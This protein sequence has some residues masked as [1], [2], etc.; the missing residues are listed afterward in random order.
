MKYESL[1]TKPVFIFLIFTV[2]FGLMLVLLFTASNR[3][4]Q[5]EEYEFD[6]W[7][8][9][10]SVDFVGSH[11]VTLDLQ[12]GS[13]GII[14][15]QISA[16]NYKNQ[17]Q[18]TSEGGFSFH[19]FADSTGL[20][21]NSVGEGG[22][23]TT[24][25]LT[26]YLKNMTHITSDLEHELQYVTTP[27]KI[28]SQM[29]LE[30]GQII[31]HTITEDKSSL[32]SLIGKINSAESI[33]YL[34]E[35]N[36]RTNDER[37][38]KFRTE[39]YTTKTEGGVFILNTKFP[40]PP[41]AGSARERIARELGVTLREAKQLL[42]QYGELRINNAIDKATKFSSR[43]TNGDPQ[44]AGG[45]GA[46][47]NGIIPTRTLNDQLPISKLQVYL[48]GPE[49]DGVL[50]DSTLYLR[51][52]H[53]KTPQ[54]ISDMPSTIAVHEVNG[55]S[56]SGGI[57]LMDNFTF[58][59]DCDCYQYEFNQDK[60]LIDVDILKPGPYV[61]SVDFSNARHLKLPITITE[62]KRVIPRS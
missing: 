11:P 3:E 53:P 55:K 47:A 2:V 20:L 32:V 6:T 18:L 49:Y 58:N 43:R 50:R 1:R 5:G 33:I 36:N 24:K 41:S 27:D 4:A 26:K 51:V 39:A 14:I 57:F 22:S 56:G 48:D 29:G 30:K 19:Q 61:L 45:A 38:L 42:K 9:A 25:T 59:K 37:K 7:R 46:I 31:S 10:I 23:T 44:A 8:G 35:K 60:W 13:S 28:L 52:F 16:G 34:P 17:T 12:G 62:D 40:D 15:T 21:V 54:K